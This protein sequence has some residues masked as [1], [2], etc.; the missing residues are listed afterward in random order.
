MQTQ[1]FVAA[2]LI[3]VMAFGSLSAV[4]RQSQNGVLAGKATD[5]AKQPYSNYA[6]QLRDV[7]TGQ[8]VS[9][10]PLDNLGAFNFGQLTLARAYLVELVQI[11]EKK[12]ACTEGP[13]TLT[14]AASS[15]LDVNVSCGK[16]P[17]AIWLLA[18]GAGAA[19]AI[20]VTTRSNSR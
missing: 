2:V 13:F 5:E 15:K 16:V 17:A 9:T 6:I 7:G 18:A 20:A 14:Q 12:I 8:V 11:K 10:K 3:A 1:R 19:A 4:A